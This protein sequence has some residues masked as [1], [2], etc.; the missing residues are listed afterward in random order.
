MTDSDEALVS[1]LSELASV[2]TER[3][4]LVS[5]SEHDL[6]GRVAELSV[7]TFAAEAT[8]SRCAPWLVLIYR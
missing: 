8:R 2:G 3:D 4:P 7:R 5:V 6:L 1:A